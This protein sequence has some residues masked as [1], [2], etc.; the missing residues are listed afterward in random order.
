V[1]ARDRGEPGKYLLL[2]GHLRIEALKDMGKTDV[3]CLIST[4]DEAIAAAPIY[5]KAHPRRGR[6]R[7]PAWRNSEPLSERTIERRNA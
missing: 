5:A 3:V 7:K 4:D 1:V 2:D 6:P